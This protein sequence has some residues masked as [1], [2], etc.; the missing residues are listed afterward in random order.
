MGRVGLPLAVL[1]STETDY[2][3]IGVE[4]NENRRNMIAAY[5]PPFFE[6]LLDEYFE[7]LKNTNFSVRAPQAIEA[8]IHIICV[9]TEVNEDGKFLDGP[10]KSVIENLKSCLRPG[11]LL[12]LRSTVPIG[13]SESYIVSELNCEKKS[14][15]FSHTPER[16]FQGEVLLGLKTLPQICGSLNK[17]SELK[18][19]EFYSSFNSKFMSLGS[20]RSAEV[21]KLVDNA[22]RDALFA[23]GNEVAM[24][25]D[26]MGVP[27]TEIINKANEYFKRKPIAKPGLVGGSCLTKDPKHL[28]RSH[29]ASPVSLLGH[30]RPLNR[31]IIKHALDFIEAKILKSSQIT[32]LGTAFK[33]MPLTDDLRGTPAKWLMDEILERNPSINFVVWD[34]L[35]MPEE[36]EFKN[37]I[38][39]ESILE[40]VKNSDIVFCQIYSE[41]IVEVSLQSVLQ[42]LDAESLVYDFWGHFES[43]IDKD[44][45]NRYLSFGSHCHYT[46]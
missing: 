10:L 3:V 21:I 20:I 19:K 27:S 41:K 46:P 39:K 7:R 30:S 6:A 36:L 11:D 37:M 45:R 34:P 43:L 40:A 15:Y 14:I 24:I 17:E 1:L 16:C 38:R 13:T 42:E 23:L 8:N 32:I 9:G 28:M 4:P 26:S 35:E 2:E 12:L 44:Q 33:G 31:S 22:H 29:R 18:T 5:K 25:C